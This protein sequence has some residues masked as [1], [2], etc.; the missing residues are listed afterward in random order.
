MNRYQ[1]VLVCIFRSM[2]LVGLVYFLT[3]T[4][5]TWVMMPEMMGMGFRVL[6]PMIIPSL[7]LF[8]VAVPLAKLVTAGVSED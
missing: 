5:V 3:S 2:G 6:L 7:V 8:F 1:K 4:I